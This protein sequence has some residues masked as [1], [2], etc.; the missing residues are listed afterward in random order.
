MLV[1]VR[2][3]LVAVRAVLV[4][5]RTVLVA[6][7]TVLVA[8]CAALGGRAARATAAGSAGLCCSSSL[9]VSGRGHCRRIHLFYLSVDFFT[10]QTS[11]CFLGAQCG[12]IQHCV[13]PKTLI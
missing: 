6:V 5:V 9:G 12:L 2:A 10:H 3:V 11:D 13:A 8:G 1:A 4:A 7:R